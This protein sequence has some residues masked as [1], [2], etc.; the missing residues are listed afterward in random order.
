MKKQLLL[1]VMMLLPMMAMADAVVDVDGINADSNRLLIVETTDGV[2]ISFSLSENPELTF[3]GKTML[4]TSENESQ[5]FEV[6][7]I[8]KWYFENLASNVNPIEKFDKPF[9][10]KVNNEVILVE[11][12]Q[13]SS[14]VQI[15]SIDGKQQ[16]I[17]N[18]YSEGEKSVINIANLP[19]GV[20]I[21]SINKVYNF[22]IYKK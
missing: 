22:K 6:Y 21:V 5:Q 20:Y 13:P 11:G 3:N 15:Y 2:K 7:N 4:I 19:N 1:L 18:S 9:I 12:L 10:K 14:K 8:S 17:Q 16:S